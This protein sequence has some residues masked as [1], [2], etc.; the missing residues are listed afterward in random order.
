MSK[1][2]LENDSFIPSNA[3]ACILTVKN[4]YVVQLRDEKP[5]I[6]FPGFWSLFGG[7]IEKNEKPKDA[8]KREL[9]EELRLSKNNYF[10]YFTTLHYDYSFYGL[11]KYYRK[12][13]TCNIKEDVFEKFKLGEGQSFKKFDGK[14]LLTKKNFV[15]YDYFVIWMHYKKEQL[16]EKNNYKKNRKKR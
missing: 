11:K 6:F 4:K 9:F 5:N 13:Y 7:Q 3:V 2:F 1:N 12:Y 8:L 16:N 15:P 14:T 10:K